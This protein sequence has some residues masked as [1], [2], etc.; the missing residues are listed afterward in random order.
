MPQ[1]ASYTILSSRN[2]ATD[3]V[4]DDEFEIDLEAETN[5]L[6][7]NVLG[8]S[9]A[10]L[11]TA[12]INVG[13]NHGQVEIVVTAIADATST[14]LVNPINCLIDGAGFN[15][16]PVTDVGLDVDG[17]VYERFQDLITPFKVVVESE[18]MLVV[19]VSDGATEDTW[20]V[21][22]AIDG[23]S[24]ATHADGVTILHYVGPEAE[25][26][27]VDDASAFA[28]ND[29]IKIATGGAERMLVTARNE[30]TDI[31]AVKRGIW[32]TTPVAI[33]DNAVIWDVIDDVKVQAAVTSA[34]A[35][36]YRLVG[37]ADKDG[38]ADVTDNRI[39]VL[40]ADYP[41]AV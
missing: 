19:S 21:R 13:I 14:E 33:A 10:F 37:A 28:V 3:T 6:L 22:R 11:A 29:V 27:R 39:P 24:I 17:G 40:L 1:R 5:L 25:E 32:G 16:N 2:P 20:V 31:I 23:T 9:A 4:F 7:M 36:D 34:S 18:R 8:G 12:P 35:T 38:D 41:V 26:F 30:T 15:A